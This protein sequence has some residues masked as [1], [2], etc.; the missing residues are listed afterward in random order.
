[1]E[2]YDAMNS[3]RAIRRLRPDPIDTA[4]LDR[5]Y[6]A[7]TWA[8]TGGNV[9]PWRLVA[10]TDPSKKQALQ[11]LYAPRWKGYSATYRER[12]EHLGD[13]A[14]ARAELTLDAGDHLAANLGQVP[15][16]AVFCFNPSIMAITDS[17][18]PRTTVV[19]GG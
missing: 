17:E 18:Q 10:V 19:G 15:V 8:P 14:K 4:T 7:A 1:M 16:I 5:I 3:L 9:Q 2:I 6:Q 13:E 11:D 12:M